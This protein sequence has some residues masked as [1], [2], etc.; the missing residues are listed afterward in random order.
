MRI[1]FLVKGL[2]TPRTRYRV[3]QY[4]P[5]LEEKGAA[6]KVI[7]IPHSPV[8]RW[9]VFQTLGNY[10]VVVIQKK[11]FSILDFHLLRKRVR[12]LI[13]DVDDAVMVKPGPVPHES[14]RR[15]RRFERTVKGCDLVF[16]GNSYLSSMVGNLGARS[17][18]VPTCIDL[19]RYPA[20]DHKRS[21][22]D[23]IL[24]LGWI[25]SRS[26]LPHLADLAPVFL[27][28]SKTSMPMDLT[29]ICDTFLDN[30][31][32]PVRKKTWSKNTEVAD[33]MELD[34]GLAP[35]PEDAWTRGKSATKVI[36]YMAAGLPVVCSPVGA[37]ADIVRD[38]V[39]GYYARNPDEW[40]DNI[41]HL[42]K[43]PEARARMGREGRKLV[44]DSYS[45]Q[46]VFPSMYVGL[47][48]CSGFPE[49]GGLT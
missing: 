31:G 1:A 4:L 41:L 6:A 40:V 10:D 39:T 9:S 45:V 19:D 2:D 5:Y 44:E 27:G 20:P 34:V 25:G 16:A 37:N 24:H 33:L 36:Q 3:T 49:S 48:G 13:F 15:R 22:G 38:G 28:L 46:A 29:I 11:L 43:D 8:K 26:T 17:I 12:R 32:I 7:D 23:R 14:W 47:E 21:R 30:V 42:A 35:L 18:L